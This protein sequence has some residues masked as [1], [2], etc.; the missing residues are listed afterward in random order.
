MFHIHHFLNVKTTF[1]CLSLTVLIKIA[2]HHHFSAR[3]LN[4]SSLLELL[5]LAC[6]QIPATAI[7]AED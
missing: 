6:Y 2:P 4:R 3:K 5:F 1:C 7:A